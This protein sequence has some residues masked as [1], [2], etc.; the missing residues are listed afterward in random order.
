MSLEFVA[1]EDTAPTGTLRRIANDA[2]E[3]R[4]KFYG[5]MRAN[6]YVPPPPPEPEPVAEP[7]PSPA[8]VVVTRRPAGFDQI[9]VIQEYVAAHYKMEIEEL[10]ARTMIFKISHPRQVAIFFAREFTTRSWQQIGQAFGGKDRST[11]LH[12]VRVTA[13]REAT[14]LVFAAEIAEMRAGLKEILA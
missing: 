11:L 13:R 6:W 4:L 5:R 2:R 9:P 8:P 12:A 7:E 14:D 10:L 1:Y 3:R